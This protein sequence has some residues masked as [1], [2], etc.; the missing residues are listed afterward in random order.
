LLQFSNPLVNTKTSPQTLQ[1]QQYLKKQ[2]AASREAS[3]A[4][5]AILKA[6]SK[7]KQITVPTLSSPTTGSNRASNSNP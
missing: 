3:A 4:T 7:A 1:S 2:A 5:Q 6:R